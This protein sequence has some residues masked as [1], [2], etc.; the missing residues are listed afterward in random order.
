MTFSSRCLILLCCFGVQPL[1][2]AE[3]LRHPASLQDQLLATDPEFLALEADLRGDARRG[4]IV[5]FK[6]AA[7]CVRC[8]STSDTRSPLGPNLSQFDEPVSH[9][10]LIDAILRP[11][12]SI[13]KGYETVAVLKT[14]GQVVQGLQV[15]EDDE[16]IELRDATDLQRSV[17][18]RKVDVE[19]IRRSN[20][21][22]MPEG[23]AG[24]LR[25]QR[26]F[27]DLAKYLFEISRGGEQRAD[28]LKPTDEQ[29][30]VVDD[31]QNL[32]HA[33]II[34]R[35]KQRDFDTGSA[36]FH[37]YCVNCHGPDGNRPS[38]A[39]ARAFGTQPLKFGSDPYRM[40][41]TLTRG[42]GLMAPMS[43]LTPME[44][45]QVV[46]YIR[47]AFM[48]DRNP[49]YVKIDSRYLDS[50]PKGTEKG[51][52]IPEVQR[53]F[54]PALASQLERRFPSVL[55]IPMG[56]VTLSYDLHTMDQAGLWSGGF[57]DLSE[58]QHMRPRGEGTANP[59]GQF[60]DGLQGWRWAHE[61]RFDYPTE[62]VL[63]RG[64]LP[65]KWMD[66]H[67]H[68]LHDNDVV[69][70]YS[71]DGREI[72][73]WPSV[74]P[75]DDDNLAVR[76]VMEIDPG[77]PLTLSVAQSV[78]SENNRGGVCTETPSVND[79]MTGD[80]NSSVAYC[81][82]NV[83]GKSG[84]VSFAQVRG[85]TNGLTWQI[86]DESRIVLVIPQSNEKRLIEIRRQVAT[87]ASAFGSLVGQWL[88][89]PAAEITAETTA[90][91]A[92]IQSMTSGGELRWPKVIS[93]IGYP[94]LENGA[95]AL[96]TITIPDESPSNT[97]FRT[98]A[99]DFLPDGRMVVAMY[100]GDVWIVSGIDDQLTGLQWKR[101]AAGLYEPFG[102]RV[103]DGQVYLTCKDRLVRLHDFNG[104]DE[105][106]F[107]E[108]FSAETDVSVNFH[109]F[110]FDLQVDSK[111]NFYYAKSG[112]GADYSLPGAVIK[113]SPDGSQRSV[114]S[115]GF[116][117]PNG[118]GMLPDDRVVASDNQ[119]QWT[120]ASKISVLRQ[121]G[122]YGWVPTYNIAGKWS[123]DG[124]KIDIKSIV[125]PTTFDRPMIW[126]P[127]EFDNS[128]GGQL[129]VDDPRWGPLSGRLLHTSFGKGWMSYTMM[130]RVDEV[131]QAA[132]VKLPF[133]FRTGIMRARVN[134][135]DGQVYACGL[136]GWNGGGRVGLL[137]NGVQRLRYTGKPFQMVSD[138]Q[139]ESD[140]LLIRFNFPLDPVSATDLQN[141]LA[142]YWNYHWR[143]D[144][145][146][147]MYSP[148]T[149][150]PGKE[151][152]PVSTIS[153]T[154]DRMAMKLHVTDL[155]PVDQVHLILKVKDESGQPFEEEIYWTINRVPR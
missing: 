19:A 121:G 118:I 119:G 124:G 98:S 39:T 57:L 43:Q 77:P 63:P 102:L 33:G 110:N 122:F 103:V 18:I 71:I 95:Y 84:G 117:T 155:K 44:R 1:A 105:A 130:Q 144:Y 52:R 3:T 65:I 88:N 15:K 150:K 51:D 80:A 149:D 116:R 111:G 125:P 145:G 86:D 123:P 101:F 79:P 142:E 131:D 108:S 104:D 10:Y 140:G 106:D 81:E 128:C 143:S 83:G 30:A 151:A 20:K 148:T 115:T 100:G 7:A 34:K 28:E 56:N 107:Y 126:M 5:F 68:Y 113:V 90:E 64:P 129:W 67:G 137:E 93:T 53:D 37:G 139:V 4:A 112:H 54:G 40:F 55:S 41:M 29:L 59:R 141:H 6:S 120:P 82:N 9:R 97:W 11:S 22:M 47:E 73:E 154:P 27:Y 60:I 133:D 147:D 70:S 92:S 87:S 146:S 25:D 12:A 24:T 8:H 45:Y 91:I 138:C 61:G 46:H 94:G 96:D 99:L 75:Q 38:L 16:E 85:D 42:G 135:A 114:L 72:K 66:Y 49:D 23:L 35:L 14:D 58:T 48:K 31:S 69:L 13:R 21:S 78:A 36:I 74:I 153:L 89:E 76:H 26:E 32:D 50:L 62:D 136:Q 132:I 109:A 17:V 152:I 127:Q 134:P 2:S